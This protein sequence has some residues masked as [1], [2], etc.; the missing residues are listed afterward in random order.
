MTA[1]NKD[2]ISRWGEEADLPNYTEGIR[3]Q[4]SGFKL[5]Q[6]LATAFN[7]RTKPL[8][9]I[10][11]YVKRMVWNLVQDEALNIAVAKFH[12][13]NAAV[14]T[15]RRSSRAEMA[16]LPAAGGGS[17]KLACHRGGFMAALQLAGCAGGL[18]AG[19]VDSSTSNLIAD[20]VQL[21]VASFQRCDILVMYR[22][23]SD[24]DKTFLDLLVWWRLKNADFLHLAIL[25]R[26]VLDIPAT[27]NQSAC[28]PA[29]ATS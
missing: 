5:V 15:S 19:G 3:R 18:V 22:E 25:A 14:L 17:R 7:P 26:R 4:S 6:V 9:G 12:E 24:G 23:D 2:F 21:E 20:S 16:P 28:S 1:L 10:D 8:S 13:A 11:D 29:P 27:R